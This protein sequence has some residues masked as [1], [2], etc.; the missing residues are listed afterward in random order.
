MQEDVYSD[1]SYEAITRA[2]QRFVTAARICLSSDSYPH[3][4]FLKS[5]SAQ[6]FRDP[7][8]LL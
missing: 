3:F 2:L 6:S 4:I 8:I 5:D 7:Y 1:V